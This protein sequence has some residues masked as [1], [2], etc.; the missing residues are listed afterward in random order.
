MTDLPTEIQQARA[1]LHHLGP[2]PGSKERIYLRVTNESSGL[3][4]IARRPML[5]VAALCVSSTAFGFGAKWLAQYAQPLW[6]THAAAS[7]K[8]PAVRVPSS[9]PIQQSAP[10]AAAVTHPDSNVALD[11][12]ASPN[13]PV[14]AAASMDGPSRNRVVAPEDATPLPAPAEPRA[15]ESE[16]SQQVAD[17]RRA[18][19]QTDPAAALDQLRAHRR[20][21]GQ[22]PIAHE[23]DL[24]I[25]E[26]LVRLGRRS[27]SAQAARQFLLNYPNSA[28]AA[29]VRRIAEAGPNT[30][31]NN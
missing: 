1:L 19:A 29:D 20:K 21:W 25:I 2:P 10:S 24:R 7:A 27:E 3:G 8:Q 6:S 26:A 28:R 17:Y 15:V 5:I 22:S 14:T 18:I 31:G 12:T 9:H 16:L 13:N 30:D 11:A 4:P 23:V